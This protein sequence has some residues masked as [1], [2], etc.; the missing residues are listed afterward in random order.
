MLE[1]ILAATSKLAAIAEPFKV[2]MDHNRKLP[3]QVVDLMRQADLLALWLPIEYGGPDV[4]VLNSIRSHRSARA[5][6]WHNRM[7]CLHR[8]NQQQNR[9][10]SFVRRG[11]CDF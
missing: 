4:G 5:S 11:E 1:R 3:Q 9:V 10:P 6:R 8:S 7:V 2:Q